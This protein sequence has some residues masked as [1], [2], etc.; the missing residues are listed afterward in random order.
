M[1][2]EK[3]ITGISITQKEKIIVDKYKEKLGIK[4][5]SLT[6]G[7]IIRE[8]A[9]YKSQM[10]TIPKAGIIDGDKIQLRKYWNSPDGIEQ[11]R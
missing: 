5:F 11:S 6:L 1:T 7:M 9:Q 3:Y 10:V 2:T 4:S 8:W